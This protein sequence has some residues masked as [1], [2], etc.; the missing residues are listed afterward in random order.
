MKKVTVE[1]LNDLDI[2]LNV[3]RAMHE[4][5]GKLQVIIKKFAP[6]LSEE[7][8]GLY[9]KWMGEIGAELGNTKEEQ[10]RHYKERFLLNIYIQD[11]EGHPGF[12]EMAAS[13]RAIKQDNPQEY[14][15]IRNQIIDLVSI[16]SASVDNMRDYLKEISNDARNLN[17]RLTIPEMKG[18]V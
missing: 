2:V 18:L 9:F 11:T 4:A 10:H 6:N 1:N 13:I 5:Q 3:T 8:R 12:A 15:H 16:T 14:K 7:Q 17:I